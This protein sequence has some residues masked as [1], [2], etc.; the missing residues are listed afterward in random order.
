MS[1]SFPLQTTILEKSRIFDVW[2]GSE[3]SSAI[4]NNLKHKDLSYYF[5]KRKK[6]VY[7]ENIPKKV[8]SA[9]DK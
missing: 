4:S 2:L 9:H 6:Q 7:F 5:R 1:Y 3:G 8:F